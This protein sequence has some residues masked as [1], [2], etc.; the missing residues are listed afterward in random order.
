MEAIGGPFSLF[1]SRLSV[2]VLDS[3]CYLSPSPD[4]FLLDPVIYKKREDRRDMK[5]RGA[6]EKRPEDWFR[7]KFVVLSYL[8]LHL[9]THFLLRT[10]SCGQFCLWLDVVSHLLDSLQSIH[11]YNR[12][13][14]LSFLGVGRRLN[15]LFH[16]ETS[17][18]FRCD[19]FAS[20]FV[21][22]YRSR[23]FTLTDELLVCFSEI[24]TKFGSL[25]ERSELMSDAR[26]K[27][28][29]NMSKTFSWSVA[30]VLWFLRRPRPLRDGSQTSFCVLFI[31]MGVR[32]AGLY[33]TCSLFVL[34]CLQ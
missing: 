13:S 10:P 23:S 21:A 5:A 28:G 20:L 6:N 4:L 11:S 17:V 19:R 12:V 30:A 33:S 34:E 14:C 29:Q 16:S 8:L 26:K 7:K 32:P 25:I 27:W 3:P 24:K 2:F 9:L 22:S 1:F 31:M 18:L 15:S